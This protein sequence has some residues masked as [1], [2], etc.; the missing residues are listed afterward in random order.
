MYCKS[1]QY[2]L[3]G[4]IEPRCPE[5]GRRFDPRDSETWDDR[6]RNKVQRLLSRFDRRHARA[7]VLTG[8]LASW[9]AFY[10][11]LPEVSDHH[12]RAS[13]PSVD[14]GSVLQAWRDYQLDH[15][16]NTAFPR[17]AIMSSVPL[18]DSYLT[19]Q[20]TW[21]ARERLRRRL[22]VVFATIVPMGVYL[23]LLYRVFAPSDART[24]RALRA[25]IVASVL[26]LASMPA[27]PKWMYPQSRSYVDEYVYVEPPVAW[28]P[29]D[30]GNEYRIVAYSRALIRGQRIV[31]F[32]DRNVLCLSDADFR[33]RAATQGI[34]VKN[35]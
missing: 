25:L 6:P 7:V 21:N 15:P 1:C 34:A 29:T 28:S 33:A 31:G 3:R 32:A 23:I 30:E 24:G 8:L 4:Q 14:L 17:N 10:V 5:C 11:A 19:G 18:R 27:W 2:D 26:I 16:T 22:L 9:Y 12:G 20:A 13:F 35:E